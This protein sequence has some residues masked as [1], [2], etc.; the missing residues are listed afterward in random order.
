MRALPTAFFAIAALAGPS[1]AQDSLSR[2]PAA[3]RPS[4]GPSLPSGA[5]RSRPADDR[6]SSCDHPAPPRATEDVAVFLTIAPADTVHRLP[7]ELLALLAQELAAP[8]RRTERRADGGLA[9]ASA[10]SVHAPIALATSAKLAIHGSG[11]VSSLEFRPRADGRLVAAIRAGFDSLVARGGIGPFTDR[12]EL[13]VP[14]VVSFR[15]DA[16]STVGQA[17]IFR[18]HVPP[19]RPATVLPGNRP[20]RY[21]ER[22]RSRGAEGKVLLQFVVDE[23][24]RPQPATFKSIQPTDSIPAHLLPLFRSFERA[25]MEIVPSYRFEP[26]ESLGCRVKMYVQMPFTFGITR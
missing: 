19:D 24:G 18:L 6:G 20:P 7:A 12:P 4:V 1:L 21:P 13:V 22:A 16:D 25:V 10:D 8:L 23:E 2:E 14:L 9:L 5:L 11:M 15:T 26:A 17:P 3:G